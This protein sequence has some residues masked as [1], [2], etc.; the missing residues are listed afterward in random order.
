VLHLQ[1]DIAQ[2]FPARF[3]H[4]LIFTE[5]A[6]L[7]KGVYA[8]NLHEV[9]DFKDVVFAIAGNIA[10]LDVDTFKKGFEAF[11]GLET[12]VDAVHCLFIAHDFSEHLEPQ[13]LIQKMHPLP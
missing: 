9:V 10:F 4:C 7:P 1:E 8:L 3:D 5:G 12:E 13:L 6:N 2:K 11:I